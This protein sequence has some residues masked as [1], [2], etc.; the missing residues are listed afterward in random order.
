MGVQTVRG[1]DGKDIQ[2][3]EIDFKTI[4]EEWNEY[5]LGDG[6]SV[7]VKTITLKV[8]LIL[9]D[10]GNPGLTAEGDPNILVRSENKITASA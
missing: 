2:V 10:D 9:D 6:T 1:P 3:Q 5:L 7:K 4:R 8:F